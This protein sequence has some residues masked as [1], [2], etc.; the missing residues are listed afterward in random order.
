MKYVALLAASYLV[1][2]FVS[3]TIFMG[4]S[5]EYLFQYFALAWHGGGELPTF[6]N[7][8]AFLFAGIT[9]FTA[10]LLIRLKRR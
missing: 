6:I 9:T 4:F 7:F 1:G 3:Y 10:W 5:Y 2:W 8:G